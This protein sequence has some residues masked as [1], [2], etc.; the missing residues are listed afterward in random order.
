MRT[1]TAAFP[2]FALALAACAPSRDPAPPPPASAAP[3]PP[4][5]I[6]V[7]ELPSPALPGSGEA[8][9]ALDAT[10]NVLLTWIDAGGDGT[11]ALRLSR[12]EGDAWSVPVT[13]HEGGD[14][15]ANWADTPRVGA[16]SAGRLAVS[17]PRLKAGLAG[18]D[19]VVQLSA[20]DGR[21]WSAPVSPHRDGM[22]TTEHDF[23][24]FYVDPVGALGIA[25]LD[26]RANP[27]REGEGGHGGA[28][29]QALMTATIAADG[30]F[31]PERVIDGRACDCCATASV[32][33]GD[34]VVLAYR[35]RSDDE[36]R[37]ISVVRLAGG[38]WSQ[39]STI[40]G[41]GWKIAGCPVNGPAMA[42]NGA[43]VALAWYTSPE[44]GARV[45][46]A[47]SSDGGATFGAP[48]RVDDGAPVGRASV[49]LLPD[50]A[51]LIGWIEGGADAQASFRVRLVEP[52]GRFVASAIVASVEAGRA[53]GFPRLV[54]SGGD[55]IAAWT[56]KD[57]ETTRVRTARLRM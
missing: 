5:S 23:P 54:A 17:W 45:K 7:E 38:E 56:S 20:D 35:D 8:D 24:T 34:T 16:D 3:P 49:A 52:G 9:L 26:G 40:S 13:V 6:T 36:V 11:R 37:D 57:G 1:V 19:V 44:T 55:V 4:R 21:T 39:P 41:D 43:S 29:A 25:W 32:R 14:L 46:L 33:S 48:V 50:G 18:Y 30:T 47:F 27:V 31:G 51:A 2:L 42:A 53:G 15:L 12:R 10:G 28:G 22:L